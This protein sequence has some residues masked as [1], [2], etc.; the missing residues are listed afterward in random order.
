MS[1]AHRLCRIVQ[2]LAVILA[3][4]VTPLAANAQSGA[5]PRQADPQ[6][7][8][9]AAI[10]AVERTMQQG[11]AS[12]ALLD[13]AVLALPQGFAFV[14]SAEAGRLLLAMGNR[15]GSNLVGLILGDA[16]TGTDWMLV[17]RWDKSGYVKDDEARDWKADELL[18]SLR[19]GTEQSN[20]ERRSRGI[21]EIEVV[22]WVE[23]PT[24]NAATQRLIWSASLREKGR[25]SADMG[26]NYNTYALGREG[27]FSFNLA[28]DLSS[29][30]R[31][32]PVALQLLAALSYNEGRRYSDFNPATDAVA[33]Y[34]IAA[35][36][37]GAAAK[38]L[39]LFAAIG[40]FLL[41]FWKILALVAIAVG[42][43]VW[44]YFRRSR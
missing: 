12:I 44:Q 40:V 28:T 32:K 21:A 6:K 39:G 1:P 18:A 15:P 4:G 23:K 14:P 41:K 30:E 16:S 27:Y 24:Y 3:L 22:G 38:K 34:G 26:V 29:I 42:G 5:P 17:V 7:E 43:G 10:Q 20:E 9:Q 8:M 37:A 33:G 2:F 31:N 36:V 25:S 19:E 11:P 35:L 13:Q